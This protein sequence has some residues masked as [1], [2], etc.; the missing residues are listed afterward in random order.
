MT[1]LGELLARCDVLAD[2]QKSGHAQV[3]A[4]TAA[5]RE[6][7][8]VMKQGHLRHVVKI[9]QVAAVEKPELAMIFVL[10]E[11]SASYPDFL[12]TAR[13]IAAEALANRELLVK[14]GLSDAAL[15]GLTASITRFGEAMEQ[16][17]AARQTH[18]AATAELEEVVAQMML[19]VRALDGLNKVRF[20]GDPEKLAA[21][22]TASNIIQRGRRSG[23]P[24]P[25]PQEGQ[26]EAAQ[27]AA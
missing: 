15:D 22:R 9:A 14:Y 1:H 7:R 10:P 24:Q 13:T 8:R 17:Q 23:T 5:K 21:W 18:V 25:G 11:R 19:L 16:G 26:G 27:S 2:Q 6:L 4:A 20:A 3:A 12:S